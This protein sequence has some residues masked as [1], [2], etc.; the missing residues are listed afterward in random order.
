MIKNKL[1]F[2]TAVIAT[3]FTVFWNI[4]DLTAIP[5]ELIGA[6]LITFISSVTFPK[7]P[8]RYA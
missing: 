6:I 7:G 5:L 1:F 4:D 8:D 2:V 3:V